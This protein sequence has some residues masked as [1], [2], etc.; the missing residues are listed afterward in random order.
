MIQYMSQKQQTLLKHKNEYLSALAQNTE[1]DISP[2][3]KPGKW[4]YPA[5]C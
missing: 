2:A 1:G 5:R 3:V 4:S